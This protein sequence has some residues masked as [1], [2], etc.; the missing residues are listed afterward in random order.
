GAGV[1]THGAGETIAAVRD[2]LADDARRTGM[3]AAMRELAT[4]SA[5]ATIAGLVFGARVAEPVLILT[6]AN[7]AGHTRVAEAIAQAIRAD[8]PA[9][10][11]SIVDVADYM[12]FA[13][14]MTHVTIYLWLVRV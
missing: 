3:S 12:S 7:G 4:P 2:L 11:V 6:I 8:D 14:R 9:T 1:L 13:T 10:P 5:A